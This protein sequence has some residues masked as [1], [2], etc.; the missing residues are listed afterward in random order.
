MNFIFHINVLQFYEPFKAP[1][2]VYYIKIICLAPYD[3]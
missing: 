2:S 3:T 1:T